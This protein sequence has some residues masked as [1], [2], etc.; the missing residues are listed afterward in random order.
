MKKY[1]YYFCYGLILFIVFLAQSCIEPNTPFK[2]E[3]VKRRVLDS[4]P[5]LRDTVDINV[6][7]LSE[8]ADNQWFVAYNK[9]QAFPNIFLYHTLKKQNPPIKISL[10][11]PLATIEYIELVDITY[12]GIYE[13]L[14]YLYYDYETS[15][16]GKETVVIKSPFDTLARNRKEVFNFNTEQIWQQ[17]DTF[18]DTMGLPIYKKR[19]GNEATLSFYENYIVASGIIQQRPHRRQT[20]R[21]NADSLIFVLKNDE[22]LHEASEEQTHS[23]S[24]SRLGGQKKLM[25]VV[26]HE[27]NCNSFVV[28]TTQGN[29]ID[30]PPTVREALL[31]A[32][33]AAISPQGEYLIY[34][35]KKTKSIRYYHFGDNKIEDILPNLNSLEG[36]SEMVWTY[37]N[38]QLK[39]AFVVINPEEYLLNTRIYVAEI[40]KKGRLKTQFFD[41]KVW[42]ECFPREGYCSLTENVDF[43]FNTA[44]NF[45]YRTQK[46]GDD[47]A[48]FAVLELITKKTKPQK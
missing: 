13:M 8:N 25:Q 23:H 41:K 6:V 16:Q 1:G 22:I 4:F 5:E 29:V 33:V 46:T 48:D 14:I 9:G 7:A 15:F 37:Q 32:N 35:D 12:D 11:R 36:I 47:N 34:A 27:R 2:P 26:A 31:C 19:I 44:G 43:K 24:Q 39:F 38:Q 45:V 18:V 21:W 10:N 30:L 17:I 3:E 20:F 28:E 42:Y 40:D